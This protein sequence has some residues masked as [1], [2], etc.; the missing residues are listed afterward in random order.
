MLDAILIPR[1][2][3]RML[4]PT[5]IWITWCD[6][7]AVRP[8]TVRGL[9]ETSSQN[10]DTALIFPTIRRRDPYI[11]LVRND[12]HQIVDILHRREGDDLPEVGESDMGLFYLSPKAYVELL[13]EFSCAVDTGVITQER[14]FL[15]FIPWLHRRAEVRTFPGLAEIESIG[16]NSRTDLNIVENYLRH[17]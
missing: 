13:A 11:H 9:N 3:I 8:E 7:I 4:E 1:D 12:K 14:N 5:G 15:P 17:Q 10:P 16:I 2:R 6:Q